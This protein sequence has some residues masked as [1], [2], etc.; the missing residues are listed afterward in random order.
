MLPDDLHGFKT[1]FRLNPTTGTQ[2]VKWAIVYKK[3]QFSGGYVIFGLADVGWH[4]AERRAATARAA[5][6]RRTRA[7]KH[8]C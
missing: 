6:R 1:T 8:P 5:G 2:T 4:G 7:A 3:Q